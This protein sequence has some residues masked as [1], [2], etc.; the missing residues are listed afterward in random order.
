VCEVSARSGV[1]GIRF[2]ESD[3]G[4]AEAWAQRIA[5]FINKSIDESA[6]G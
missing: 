3:A 2:Y 1:V 5:D 6:S 4:E